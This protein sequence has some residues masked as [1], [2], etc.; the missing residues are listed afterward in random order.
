MSIMKGSAA[1]AAAFRYI[2]IYMILLY[3][4]HT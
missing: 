3:Y 1:E 2:Y 4:I